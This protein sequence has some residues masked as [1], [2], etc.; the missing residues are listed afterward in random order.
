MPSLTQMTESEDDRLVAS[1]ARLNTGYVPGYDF[2]STFSTN[3]FSRIPNSGEATFRQPPHLVVAYA[4]DSRPLSPGSCQVH[5]K[6]KRY[7]VVREGSKT[8]LFNNW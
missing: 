5:R 4:E 7:Y 3:V 2:S 8:G 6:E 1:L